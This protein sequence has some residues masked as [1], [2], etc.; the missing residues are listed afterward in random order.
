MTNKVASLNRQ[1][2]KALSLAVAGIYFAD[3][4]DQED[5]L[6]RIVVELGGP[7]ASVLLEN[8]P[9][10]AYYKYVEKLAEEE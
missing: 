5:Y 8:D 9:T 2:Q 3:S 10:E 4:S 6:W 1:I 7:E